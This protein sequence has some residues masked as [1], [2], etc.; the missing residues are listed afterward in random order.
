MFRT[1]ISAHRQEARTEHIVI[2]VLRGSRNL[3][4]AM[5]KRR[6]EQACGGSFAAQYSW[7]HAKS[8][9]GQVYLLPDWEIH[10]PVFASL[11]WDQRS[12]GM[13]TKEAKCVDSVL[14][15]SVPRW[16][17]IRKEES[18]SQWWRCG[19]ESV[20]CSVSR[21]Q[22]PKGLASLSPLKGTPL[23]IQIPVKGSTIFP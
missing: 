6:Q 18:P 19:R 3:L 22:G 10:K 15:A 4:S 1:L 14:A 21:K 11:L 8:L 9:W 16:W 12:W 23:P 2:R 17:R 13:S 5:L 20:S 7:K